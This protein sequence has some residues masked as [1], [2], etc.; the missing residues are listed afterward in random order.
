MTKIA[1]TATRSGMTPVQLEKFSYLVRA[2][3]FAEGNNEWHDG[4]CVGGD[5][6][7]HRVVDALKLEFIR[8][9]MPG[10]KTVGHPGDTPRYYASNVFDESWP[11]ANNIVRNHD[12]VDAVEI[13]IAC[14]GEFEEVQRSGTWATIRYA[15]LVMKSGEDLILL[16]IWPDG[17]MERMPR[18]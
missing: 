10:I 14:P 8:L 13:L 1:V 18:D 12:M 4:D 3:F 7:A 11:I 5:D 6:Q 15:K 17:R 9:G 16:V 2:L